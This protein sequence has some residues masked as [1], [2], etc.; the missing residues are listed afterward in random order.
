MYSAVVETKSCALCC[1]EFSS[2]AHK[3]PESMFRT[4]H[5]ATYAECIT[6]G[7]LTRVSEAVFADMY[8]ANYYSISSDPHQDFNSPLRH[9]LVDL[10]ATSVFR[11]RALTVRALRVLAPIKELRTACRMLTSIHFAMRGLPCSSILDVGTGSGHLPYILSSTNHRIVGIDPFAK[12]EWSRYSSEIVRCE[13]GSIT[14]TFDLVMFHHS[15]EHVSSPLDDLEA[16]MSLLSPSGRIIIRIPK[17]DSRAWRDFG[18]SWFQ[19]DAPRH[20]FVPT[21]KGL[22]ALLSRAG[23]VV[24]RQYDDSSSTQFWLSRLVQNGVSQM[25]QEVGYRSFRSNPSNVLTRLRDVML[26]SWCNRR[27]LGDQVVVIAERQDIPR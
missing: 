24:N 21:T 8:P 15:L 2:V 1:S 18:T 6:C 20:E 13:L 14:E 25:N 7:S 16:A 12:D 11:R 17:L 5:V 3:V 19:L 22:L 9:W 27:H 26:T 4:G 23:L 10:L